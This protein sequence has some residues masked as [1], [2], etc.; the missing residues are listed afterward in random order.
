ML[1][2]ECTGKHSTRHGLW[3]RGMCGGY[4][5][6]A[7][8]VRM[9]LSVCE[10]QVGSQVMQS[11]GTRVFNTVVGPSRVLVV[12]MLLGRTDCTDKVRGHPKEIT[13]KGPESCYCFGSSP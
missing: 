6:G 7:G 12:D 9:H 11:H 2:A 4:V 8:A 3:G 10:V 13:G 1:A 5:A